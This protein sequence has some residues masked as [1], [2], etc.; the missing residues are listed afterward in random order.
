MY[1][2]PGLSATEASHSC[3][4]H[5][6]LFTHYILIIAVYKFSLYSAMNPRPQKFI[7]T[8]ICPGTV[9]LP[10]SD[11]QP[12]PAHKSHQEHRHTHTDVCSYTECALNR[13]IAVWPSG[14]AEIKLHVI[15]YE[16]I[17]S[18]SRRYLLAKI[19]TYRFLVS[20]VFI[21]MYVRC[22]FI[23]VH[24]P[25]VQL[26]CGVVIVQDGPIPLSVTMVTR[27]LCQWTILRLEVIEIILIRR[28]EWI[29]CGNYTDKGGTCKA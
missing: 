24:V 8:K 1:V 26:V 12:S 6:L 18:N 4:L 14:T 3:D 2:S 21:Y 15:F 9:S 19:S 20:V 11:R 13:N 27:L 29:E 5:Y 10:V 17:S 25:S 23:H 28:Q 22:T 7:L 16:C